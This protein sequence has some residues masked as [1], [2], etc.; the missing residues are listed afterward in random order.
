[1]QM[2]LDQNLLKQTGLVFLAILVLDATE[3]RQKSRGIPPKPEWDLCVFMS[4]LVSLKRLVRCCCS[5][6]LIL[7]IEV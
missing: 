2:W 5:S 4:V 3:E 6:S 7:P 1:M